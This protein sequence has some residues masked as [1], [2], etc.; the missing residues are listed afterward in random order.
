[1]YLFTIIF[2]ALMYLFK[3]K[4]FMSMLLNNSVC[5]EV[6]SRGESETTQSVRDTSE[7][8]KVNG[9]VLLTFQFETFLNLKGCKNVSKNSLFM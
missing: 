7:S 1:M 8:Y 4:T 2:D 9:F 5:A 3:E 6:G